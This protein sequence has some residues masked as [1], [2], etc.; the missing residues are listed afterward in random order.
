MSALFSIVRD[1]Y[2]CDCTPFGTVMVTLLFVP[3]DFATLS[4]A[5]CIAGLIEVGT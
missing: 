1:S 5:F 2:S 4:V 3:N